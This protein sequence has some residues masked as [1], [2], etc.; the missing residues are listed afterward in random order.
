MA[1][2][3]CGQKSV[4]RHV[5][6]VSKCQTAVKRRCKKEE[7]KVLKLVIVALIMLLDLLLASVLYLPSYMLCLVYFGSY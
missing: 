7:S 1:V 5:C 3:N 2:I 6:V 4:G